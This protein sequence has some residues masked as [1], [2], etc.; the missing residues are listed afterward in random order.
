MESSALEKVKVAK[1]CRLHDT[2]TLSRVTHAWSQLSTLL[3]ARKAEAERKCKQ[4]DDL[5]LA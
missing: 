2:R 1:A 4:R 3:Q 5:L